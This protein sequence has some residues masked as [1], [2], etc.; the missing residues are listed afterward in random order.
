MK[1]L[2]LTLQGRSPLLLHSDLLANPLAPET[3]RHKEMTTK[4]KKTDEDLILIA[5]SE[6][7]N[8][9][10]HDA[11]GRVVVPTINLRASFIDG[12]KLN[13]LGAAFQRGTVILDEHVPLEYD[14]PQ[15]YKKLFEVPAFVDC[16]SVVVGVKRIMRYRPRFNR[17]RCQVAVHYDESAISHEEIVLSTQNAGAFCGL[18][19]FRPTRKGPFGRYEIEV[20]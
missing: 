9:L 1:I 2:T 13:R 4:K 11:E 12:A 17:W 15:H 8:S 16:R 3:K 19:D 10:Y 20:Q 14:G 7:E 18:G 6:Y 5:Q